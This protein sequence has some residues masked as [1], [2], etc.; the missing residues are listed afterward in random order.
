MRFLHH[1]L[2]IYAENDNYVSSD[3]H[4]CIW[5]IISN[6]R[7]KYTVQV[8]ILDILVATFLLNNGNVNRATCYKLHRIPGESST[9]CYRRN[10]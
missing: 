9:G 4:V 6:D 3:V 5:L 7:R 2:P 1:S 10:R 8:V